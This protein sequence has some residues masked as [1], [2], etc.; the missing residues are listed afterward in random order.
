M[1]NVTKHRPPARPPQEMERIVSDIYRLLN[2]LMEF[3]NSINFRKLSGSDY[4]I[5]VK[6]SD[7]WLSTVSGTLEFKE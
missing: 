3:K 6:F 4:R 7:G 1:A 5:D 2:E